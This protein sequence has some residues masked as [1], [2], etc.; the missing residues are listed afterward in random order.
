MS[1]S[2][3]L[4]SLC[5]IA[6]TDTTTVPEPNESG[7][8]GGDAAQDSGVCEP[9]ADQTCNDNPAISSLH[10]RC[11]PDRTCECAEGVQKNPDTGRCL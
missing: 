11:L 4:V 7:T 2:I 8:S 1:R 6:C 10:G 9:G 5:L 3:L